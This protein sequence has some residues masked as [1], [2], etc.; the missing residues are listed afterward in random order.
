MKRIIPLLTAILLL[1]AGCAQ[2]NSDNKAD[3]EATDTKTMSE[4]AIPQGAGWYYFS[5]TGIHPA[6]NPADIPA[7]SFLPW[8]EAVRVSDAAIVNSVPALL[9]NRLGLMTSGTGT[10]APALHTDSLFAGSTAAGILRTE[11]GT[12][13]RLY[14]N[15][16]F[17]D[18]TASGD[19]TFLADYDT[20]T[21]TIRQ[22]LSAR[23]F[24]LDDAAQCVA[25]DRIGSMWY[26]SFKLEKA[27]KVDF[28]Y[29]EF[30]SFPKK[31][32][33]SYDLSGIRKIS[34]E[35][36]QKS[37]APFYWSDAPDQL[38]SLLANLPETTAF[39]LKVYSRSAR[40]T[41]TYL[42]Q[43]EGTPVDGYA[44]L[45]DDTSAVLFA[46]GTFCYSA[47]NSSGKTQTLK[48]PALSSGYVYTAFVISGKSLLAAWEEQRF[49]ETGRAGL[50]ATALPDTVY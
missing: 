9:I 49:F 45:S 44:Y 31:S 40:S 26:A 5:D 35:S 28:T 36:Y 6:P 13:I 12:A 2:R 29:L 42:R 38:K 4:S 3:A 17:G 8:T 48:L 23:D 32:E 16:F 43:G 27:G 10:E 39:T 50:L 37:V 22:S 47:D 46:D 20:A 24:A 14:R 15:S 33:S 7:R 1:S 30:E 25:L 34:S 19:G 11:S 21:G 18:G 41:Q